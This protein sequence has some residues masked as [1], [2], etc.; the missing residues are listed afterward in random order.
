MK[1]VVII[2]IAVVCSVVAVLGGLTVLESVTIMQVDSLRD[3]MGKD[4]DEYRQDLFRA[5]SYNQE[6]MRLQEFFCSDN[7]P[8]TDWDA[9]NKAMRELE[10][11]M[12][13]ANDVIVQ[14]NEI[15]DKMSLL[16]KK[17]PNNSGE[18]T[19]DVVTCPYEEEW[20]EAKKSLDQYRESQQ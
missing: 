17:Y 7:P 14:L 1:P 8:T 13:R 10:E 9:A 16:Q 4:Y 3:E 20:K 11:K 6:H 19:F 12:K 18:F 5:S 15:K 2:A